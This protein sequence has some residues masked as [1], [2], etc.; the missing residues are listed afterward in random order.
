M[1][2]SQAVLMTLEK[3]HLKDHQGSMMTIMTLFV[4]LCENLYFKSKCLL[5]TCSSA[6]G[7]QSLPP[8]STV[9]TSADQGTA[10]QAVSTQGVAVEGE[11]DVHNHVIAMMT[12]IKTLNV[13]G[14][15][16]GVRSSIGFQTQVR[17]FIIRIADSWFII[18]TAGWFLVLIFSFRLARG[19]VGFPGK[20]GQWCLQSDRQ[21][22]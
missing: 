18:H 9:T 17:M 16:A 14:L 7:T 19:R 10:D 13:S 11:C 1:N 21:P 4:Y 3:E 6:G 8:V 20:W 12:C 2:A 15:E 22:W 5:S